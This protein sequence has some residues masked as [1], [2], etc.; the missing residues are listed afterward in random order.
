MLV[1]SRR[2]GE[3]VVIPELD[4]TIRVI[5]IRRDHVRIGIDAPRHIA[6]HRKEVWERIESSPP[7]EELVEAHSYSV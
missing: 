4:I 2:E 6:V 1:L 7:A 5:E 3:E